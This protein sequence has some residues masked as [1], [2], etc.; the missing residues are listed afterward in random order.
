M[1]KILTGVIFISCFTLFSQKQINLDLFLKKSI[2]SAES[3]K[4]HKLKHIVN[5]EN[6]LFKKGY[7]PSFS[8]NFSLPSYNRSISN[9]MQPDGTFA[10]RESNSATSK[11][12]LSM[13]QKI[14]Y[15]GTQISVSNSFNRLDL[16]GDDES[17]TS[18]SASWFGINISQP[19]NFFNSMK[20]DKKI[21]KASLEESEINHRK[22][23]VLLKEESINHYFELLKIQNNKKTIIRELLVVNKYKKVIVALINA[24]K[25]ISYDSIDVELKILYKQKSLRFIK[26][27]ETL[28]IKSI[29][30][31]FEY[32]TVNKQDVLSTPVLSIELEDISFYISKY[33]EVYDI[34]EKTRLLVINKNIKELEKSRFYSANLS[35][36]IGF[37]KS[38]D[39]RD[40][41]FQ[42]PNQSQN[43]SISLD[44]PIFDF[45][46]KR[47]GLEIVK[48]QKEIEISD[49]NQEKISTI[50]HLSFLYEEVN[51]LIYSLDI[52][53]SRVKLLKLKLNRM[54]KL[55]YVQ[56]VLFK[57]YSETEDLL[58]NS[59]KDKTELIHSVYEKIIEIEEITLS[60]IIKNEY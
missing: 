10:F 5:K 54:E 49:L 25:K 50:D 14:S 28:K 21:Q 8:L 31:F 11:V 23:I 59:I 44:V 35:L 52:E 32:N 55:L 20:W 46:K 18:Y 36:G 40:N 22:S 39:T 12:S 3:I 57:D 33:L 17:E 53:K 47:T 7:L 1:S 56:R 48:I 6:E 60:E 38:S 58:Y 34:M 2:N 15:T 29:N 26:K 24:G 30:S 9:I 16:F 19:L 37:N 41:I 43:F 27:S 51:D 13:S 42:D 45:G 4:I